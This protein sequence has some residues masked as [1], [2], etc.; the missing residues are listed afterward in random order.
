MNCNVCSSSDASLVLY[1]PILRFHRLQQWMLT[2]LTMCMSRWRL[3]RLKPAVVLPWRP[4][5]PLTL[6]GSCVMEDRERLIW[7]P[8]ER[9]VVMHVRRH[10]IVIDSQRRPL[11]AGSVWWFSSRYG[12]EVLWAAC[13]CVCLF[14]CPLVYKSQKQLAQISPNF[15]FYTCY[16]WLWLSPLTVENVLCIFGFVDDIMFP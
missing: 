8:D 1:L 13:L 7:Q 14:V 5:T 4:M 12:S 6:I 3:Q 11:A 10:P 9:T 15:L 2:L 16:L